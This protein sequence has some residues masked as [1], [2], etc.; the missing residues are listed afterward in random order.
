MLVEGVMAPVELLMDK[1]A[2]ELEK[3]PP[4]VPDMVAFTGVVVSLHRV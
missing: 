1:P 2:G 4:V 3:V